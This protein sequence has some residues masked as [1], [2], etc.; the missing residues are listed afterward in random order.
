MMTTR[1]NVQKPCRPRV[2]NARMKVVAMIVAL[3]LVVSITLFTD[4]KHWDN[5]WVRIAEGNINACVA[6]ATEEILRHD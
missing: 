2:K 5:G 6:R 3:I 4:D 1:K